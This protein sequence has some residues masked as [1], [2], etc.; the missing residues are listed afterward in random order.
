[1]YSIAAKQPKTFLMKLFSYKPYSR[2]VR[3]QNL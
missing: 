3:K 2:H 1:M